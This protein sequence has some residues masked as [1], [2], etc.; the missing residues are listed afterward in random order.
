MILGIMTLSIITLGI[1]ILGIMP[2]GIM[3]NDTMH[4]L[5]VV[6]FHLSCFKD[7]H[8]SQIFHILQLF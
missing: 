3:T 4:N 1:M 6:R 5:I 8:V 7:I 2:H